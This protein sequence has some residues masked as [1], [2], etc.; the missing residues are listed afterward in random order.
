MYFFNKRFGESRYGLQGDYQFRFWDEGGDLEQILLRTGATY[1][2]K[3]AKV[4]F[5]LGY[6]NITS[7]AFGESNSTVSENRFYQ[8]VF[9][10]HKVGPRFYLTHRFRYEQRLSD[11][12]DLRTRYRYNLFINVPLNGVELGKNIF[13]LAM[14]NEIFINGEL[15]TGI[16]EV[17]YFD[18]N[19]SYLAFGYGLRE[20]LRVQLGFMKQTTNSWSKNQFQLSAHHNF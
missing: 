5:T 16:S 8:E 15:S 13:Y 19:R 11:G 10:P 14:Y 3:N 12:Q 7:G 2:P 6:A 9:L 4:T 18:R 20:N 17:E 1:S